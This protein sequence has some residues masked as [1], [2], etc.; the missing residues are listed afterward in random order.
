[1]TNR[2]CSTPTIRRVPKRT[3]QNWNMI[4]LITR[5]HDERHRNL[6]E[7][8]RPPRARKILGDIEPQTISGGGK[9]I[10]PDEISEST[11]RVRRP[12][13]DSGLIRDPN[14]LESHAN[15]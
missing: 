15:A 1:M 10:R 5:R 6:R 11:I 9:G 7:Q 8:R 3:E 13:T 14:S 12:V 4:M 2:G